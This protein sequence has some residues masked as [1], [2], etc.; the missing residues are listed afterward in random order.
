MNMAKK[1]PAS[2]ATVT[3][4]FTERKGRYDAEVCVKTA[5]HV[6]WT[7]TK[8]VWSRETP[9]DALNKAVAEIERAAESIRGPRAIGLES[10]RY[11]R[12]T[13]ITSIPK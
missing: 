3:I 7:N 6:R 5:G 10:I 9:V 11:F 12:R 1:Q 4:T 13:A 8:K 2:K